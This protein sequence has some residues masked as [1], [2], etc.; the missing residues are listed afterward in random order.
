MTAGGGPTYGVPVSR[1]SRTRVGNAGSTAGRGASALIIGALLSA[2]CGAPAP[3]SATAATATAA[4]APAAAP[5]APSAA[6]A[7]T[8][9]PAPS[10]SRTVRATRTATPQNTVATPWPAATPT[11]SSHLQSAVDAGSEPWLLDPTEVALSYVS[12]A[13][14]WTDAQAR[15]RPGGA[16]VDVQRG[17][18]QLVLSLTQPARTGAG[19]IWVVTAE[20]DPG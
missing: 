8:S 15:A 11:E 17:R 14:G 2:G 20:A 1:G 13:H 19:G 10:G 12:A 16:T 4:A 6:A 9:T 3:I 18:Q 7:P 5:A